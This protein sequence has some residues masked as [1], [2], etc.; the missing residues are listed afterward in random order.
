MWKA[1]R[2]SPRGEAGYTF[3]SMLILLV[4]AGLAAQTVFIPTSTEIR[5]ASEEELIF[6]GMA[7]ARAVQSYWLADAEAPSFPPGLDA[8]L[9]DPRSEARHIRRLYD[10]VIGENW[11]T[12]PAEGGGIA[13]V[14]LDS[15]LTPFKRSGFPV[16]MV[17]SDAAETYGQWQ[18]VF[19][20]DE[21]ET[22]D[23]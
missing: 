16:G 18:F 1:G 11:R 13:G 4:G 19:T 8:L 22:G 17:V 3:A 6:R 2:T 10:P 7:Y 21:T 9:E 12:I 23:P 14:A 15:S 5:R 20:P